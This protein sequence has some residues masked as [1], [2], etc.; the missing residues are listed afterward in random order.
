MLK[1]IHLLC[2]HCSLTIARLLDDSIFGCAFASDS[3]NLQVASANYFRNISKS[4]ISMMW[5]RGV[6]AIQ[7][8]I[9]ASAALIALSVDMEKATFKAGVHNI[10]HSLCLKNA[11]LSGII[12]QTSE[13]FGA[14]LLVDLAPLLP[15]VGIFL[16]EPFNRKDFLDVFNG[17]AGGDIEGN[18]RSTE[19]A[20][21]GVL[22]GRGVAENSLDLWGGESTASAA[23]HRLQAILDQIHN[24]VLQASALEHVTQ[25]IQLNILTDPMGA[26]CSGIEFGAVQPFR[27]EFEGGNIDFTQTNLIALCF[28]EVAI[29]SSIEIGRSLAK[30]ILM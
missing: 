5:T 9:G 21:G 7:M 13:A 2:F 26:A 19:L 22:R 23:V 28:L 24:H 11:P 17:L 3:L 16:S 29:E 1:S 18:Q 6:K 4:A 12:H 27:E 15:K 8:L 30:P 14:C 10:T 20:Q 25:N